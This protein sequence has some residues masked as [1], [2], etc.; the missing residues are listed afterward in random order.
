MPFQINEQYDVPVIE[1]QGKF[2]GSLEGPAFREQIE[3][4]KEKGKTSLVVDLSA[5][6]FMDST[7]IGILIS[8]LT[9]MR[10]AGGD[11]RLAG[12]EK[13]IRNVFLMTKLLGGVFDDYE[14]VDEAVQ[15]FEHNPPTGEPTGL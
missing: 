12:M 13:R 5:T 8:S 11:V 2:L 1:I 15:S 6:E 4:F 7:G 10:K 9:T 14:D 3:H